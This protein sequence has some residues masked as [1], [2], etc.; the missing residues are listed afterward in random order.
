[1]M[2]NSEFIN[3]R[4]ERELGEILTDT[5]K[6]LRLNYKDL[7]KVFYK[8]VGPFLLLLIAVYALYF[9]FSMNK[10]SRIIYEGDVNINVFSS[11]GFGFMGV[12]SV[13]LFAVASLLFYATYSASMNYSVKSYM[14]NNGV[15]D[16]DEVAQNVKN[17]R[18]RFMGLTLLSGLIVAA[19]I[20]FCFIP[21]V[22]LY[23]PMSL[24]F[25]IAAF[26]N[27]NTNDSI[28]FSFKL[29]K[30]NWWMSFLTLLVMGIIYTMVSYVFK[31]PETIYGL[32][33]GILFSETIFGDGDILSIYDTPYLILSI[34]GVIGQFFA[35]V[36]VIFVA[37]FIYFNLDE[38]HNQTGS[39]EA[40]DNLGSDI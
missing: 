18:G 28:S 31:V 8:V 21:G 12:L 33:K 11:V 10:A 1:M 14:E 13:L 3:F 9:Y 16:V 22:Y 17:T 15:I 29:I 34:I 23:V 19:G 39:F 6:F 38:K 26:K 4:R 24:V 20:L 7:W 25:A 36:L 30:N 27:F 32:A 5:F 40:I 2:Q 37:V 35:Y